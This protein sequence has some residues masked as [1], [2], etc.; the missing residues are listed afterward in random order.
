[1]N[2][3]LGA[4]SILAE[5][6]T[7]W[8]QIE[9][10]GGDAA[11]ALVLYAAIW[12]LVPA[13]ASFVGAVAIGV[14]MPDGGV[15]RVAAL[16]GLLGAIFS[17]VASCASVLVLGLVINLTAPAFGGRRNFDSA[18]KLAAFSYTPVWICGAF[19][20]LPGLRF[21]TLCGCYGGYLLWRGLPQLMKVPRQNVWA[22]T[23]L[24][25]A[26]AVLLYFIVGAVQHK[27]FG[28][29]RI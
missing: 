8:P 27:L 3:W 20:L 10:D 13:I 29:L 14:A 12:A 23:L 9:N 28:V 4:K 16:D 1:M 26:C 2:A 15:A 11:D 7:A 22:A 24:I 5:P 25:A 19:L 17:Y 21:L 6:T 18:I